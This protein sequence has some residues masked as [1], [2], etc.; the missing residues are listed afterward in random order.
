MVS[1]YIF[2]ALKLSGRKQAP[3]LTMLNRRNVENQYSAPIRGKTYCKIVDSY[4][5]VGCWKKRK[6][7]C[8]GR[9]TGLKVTWHENE[10]T[11]NWSF[12]A[13]EFGESIL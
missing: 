1:E 3:N 8:N 9:D 4:A 5:G 12:I 7:F 11:S 10:P 2:A 13:R 6:L